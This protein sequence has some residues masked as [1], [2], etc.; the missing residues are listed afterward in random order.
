MIP[1][2]YKVMP[3]IFY[4]IVYQTEKLYKLQNRELTFQA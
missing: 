2:K 1:Y 3:L 4:K